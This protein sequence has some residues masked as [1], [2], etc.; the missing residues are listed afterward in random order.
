MTLQTL[1]MAVTAPTREFLELQDIPSLPPLPNLRN[2]HLTLSGVKKFIPQGGLEKLQSAVDSTRLRRLS[3][4]NL[5]I[6][7]KTLST[8]LTTSPVLE[9]LYLTVNS[10]SVI[11]DCQALSGLPDLRILHITTPERFGPT[12]EDLRVLA[13][14]LVGLD[15][16]GAGNRVYE[17]FRRYPDGN[18]DGHGDG[19]DSESESESGGAEEMKVELGRWGR[20]TTPGYFQVWRG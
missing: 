8:I 6:G 13:E 1:S 4:N 10:I 14:R 20:T 19:Y 2:L 15:Q 16:I 11:I 5:V 12:T 17:V 3:L 9:E 18:G 7:P